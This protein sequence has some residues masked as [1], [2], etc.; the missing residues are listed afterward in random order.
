M[1]VALNT[2]VPSAPLVDPV[3]GQVTPAWRAFLLAL[4]QRTGGAVGQ[5]SD[6]SELE[7]QLA[8]ETAA[9]STADT[10]LATGLASEAA[11]RA[12]ADTTL[13]TAVTREATLRARADSNEATARQNADALLVPIAQLCSMW[14][15]CDL[16]FRQRILAA[17]C[18]GSTA[19]TSRWARRRRAWSA[20]EKRMARGAGAWKTARAHG[21]GARRIP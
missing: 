6:T 18:P 14:A 9:R 12:A 20:S 3:S 5:S 8:A 16:S 11:T 7:A 2:G 13:N 15:A 19:S 10:G 4:Y 21:S 1:T 17:A